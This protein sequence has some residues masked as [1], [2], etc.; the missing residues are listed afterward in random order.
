MVGRAEQTITRIAEAG[1]YIFVFIKIFVDRCRIDRDV[2]M[3]RL[4][5]IQSLLA[6]DD[7]DH[8]DLPGSAS[9]RL[10]DT[11]RNQP[12]HRAFA[13]LMTLKQKGA[14]ITEKVLKSAV[15]NSKVLGLD[16]DKLYIADIR[17][18]AGPIL[19]RFQPRS[20]GRA[21]RILK[22]TS[23]L[24]LTLKERAIKFSRPGKAAAALEESKETQKTKKKE[25]K[26][27]AS[28]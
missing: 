24:S 26:A 28:T 20:M 9:D 6:R 27:K 7:T 8:D 22:R 21:D 16:E 19:K 15:A 25:K 4:D 10:L 5:N 1:D 2:G 13:T 14:R 11:V 18:D 12:P 3:R 23:H 17:A